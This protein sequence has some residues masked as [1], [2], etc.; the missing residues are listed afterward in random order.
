MDKIIRVA[1]VE[2]EDSYVQTICEYV[3]KYEQENER[4]MLLFVYNDANLFEQEYAS[5]YDVIFM[6]VKF[7]N[8]NGMDVINRIRKRDKDVI[9][10]FITSIAKYAIKGYEVDA[11]DFILKPISYF[12]FSIKLTRIFNMLNLQNGVEI[13]VNSKYKKIKI[14]TRK[15]KYV[16]V[17]KH[18]LIYHTTD[19][20]IEAFG[21]M[22]AACEQLKGQ[23]FA[24]CNRCYLVNLAFVTAFNSLYVSIEDKELPISYKKKA[25]FINKINRYISGAAINDN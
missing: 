3:N 8:A 17:N 18:I 15:L 10:V 23:P 7:P 19:E 6:D 12:N 4:K 9:V 25:D 20:D 13:W 22:K 14:N 24:L 2:D 1:V 5:Q 21:S 11:F 16:E